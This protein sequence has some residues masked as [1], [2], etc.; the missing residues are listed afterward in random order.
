MLTEFEEIKYD[1]RVN[2]TA[3]EG[4]P[5][6]LLVIRELTIKGD[7]GEYMCIATNDLGSANATATLKVKGN[8]KNAYSGNLLQNMKY[9]CRVWATYI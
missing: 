9:G 2:T 1:T 6:A 7:R 4:V 3:K 5:D 8:T